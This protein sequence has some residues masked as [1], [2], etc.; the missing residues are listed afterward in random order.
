MLLKLTYGYNAIRIPSG[1]SIEVDKLILKFII[2]KIH[3]ELQGIQNSQNK[4]EKEEKIGVL[5]LSDFKT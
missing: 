1:I 2:Y 5:T 3:I 4:L